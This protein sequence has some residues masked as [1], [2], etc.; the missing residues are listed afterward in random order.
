MLALRQTRYRV[1]LASGMAMKP[2]Q[3]FSP[4]AWCLCQT[5]RSMQVRYHSSCHPATTAIKEAHNNQLYWRVIFAAASFPQTACVI[6]GVNAYSHQHTEFADH[7]VYTAAGHGQQSSAVP[8][9][10]RQAPC[11]YRKGVR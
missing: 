11:S 7:A 5:S 1:L 6:V 2:L 3:R 10:S 8:H 4:G 9:S